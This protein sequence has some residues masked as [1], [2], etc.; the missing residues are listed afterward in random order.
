MSAQVP[1]L[2]D[3]QPPAG[4]WDY[5]INF[6]DAADDQYEAQ[7][8]VKGNLDGQWIRAVNDSWDGSAPM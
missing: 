1:E 7:T 2:A 8:Q 5:I 4:G 6:E 3:Y